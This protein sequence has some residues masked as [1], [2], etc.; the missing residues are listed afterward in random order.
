INSDNESKKL[1]V[2]YIVFSNNPQIKLS[3]IPEYF[4]FKEIIID[5]SNY[6][7]NTDKWIAENQDL[8]FK[9]FDIREQGAFVLKIE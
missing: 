8:N 3:E 5:A 9:L 2:D 4:N 7:S 6:K 1:D